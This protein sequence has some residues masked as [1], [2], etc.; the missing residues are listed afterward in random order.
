MPTKK[1]SDPDRPDGR[2]ATTAGF[3][4]HLLTQEPE[5]AFR[6][7]L[8]QTG[9]EAWKKKV[10]RKLRE[11]L[12]FPAAPRQPAPKLIRES[13]RDGYRLQEWELYPEPHCVVPFL[14]LVPD[15]ATVSEP[16]PAVLCFP[17]SQQPKEALCG[18]PWDSPWVNRF[19]ETNF[20]AQHF[21]KAGFVALAFDNPGTAAVADPR[22]RSHQRN[23]QQ[24]VWMGRSYE[25]LSTFQKWVALK[26]LKTQP[27][28]DQQR[29]A[30]S[31]HSLGAKPALLLGVL[32]PSIRAV[33][34]NDFASDWRARDALTNLTPVALWHYT[35][36]F[37]RWFD[38]MDLMASLA[39]TPL[40][41][42]EGGRLDDHARIRKAY[43][44][45]GASRNMKVSFMPNFSDPKKRNRKKIPEGVADK[46]FG[47]WANYDGDHYY[48]TEVAVPW[49]C[50]KFGMK[51]PGG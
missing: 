25:G 43:A 27:F 5:L 50:R 51:P 31:G 3:V 2:F 19:G 39:P 47:Q 20:M 1:L 9:F 15:G 8:T 37:A 32:E 7:D 6:P 14:M 48:K 16:A 13:P 45:N 11:L 46:D 30:A 49:L 12:T 36:D 17:G 40:L 26:W 22:D 21:V 18:E 34:W 35:P 33:I 38:Y 41:I 28:V 4:H 23:S 44:L 10:R 42:S 24:L 29:I